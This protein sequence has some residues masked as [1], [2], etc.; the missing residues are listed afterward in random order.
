MSSS[1]GSAE[2][3]ARPLQHRSKGSALLLSSIVTFVAVGAVLFVSITDLRPADLF[4][5]TIQFSNGEQAELSQ[6]DFVPLSRHG[7]TVNSK[8]AKNQIAGLYAA[9]GMEMRVHRSRQQQLAQVNSG[10]KNKQQHHHKD[11]RYTN[12]SSLACFFT[13]SC[14]S[15]FP[16]F[17]SG[18]VFVGT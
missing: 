11:A 16:C 14:S 4:S 17:V 5:K 6:R 2:V 1:Y 8:Q 15:F 13:L 18:D 7:G 3:G 10:L 12:V 9:A